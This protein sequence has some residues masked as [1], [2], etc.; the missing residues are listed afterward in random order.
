MSIWQKCMVKIKYFHSFPTDEERCKKWICS[1]QRKDLKITS[2][3]RV[4]SRHF[5]S[6]DVKEPSTPK[7]RRLLKK[8]AVPTLFQ[9]NNYSAPEPLQRRK[10]STPVDED[11]APVEYDYCS[12][13]ELAAVDIALE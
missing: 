13:P 12:V 2:H 3:M 10:A 4:C 9:W 8:G 11:P 7:G 1:I 5:K 6:E